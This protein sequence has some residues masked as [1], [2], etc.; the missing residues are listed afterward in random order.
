MENS[1]QDQQAGTSAEEILE[2]SKYA[3]GLF[4]IGT[5]EDLVLQRLI[6]RGLDRD[7]AQQILALR[8]QK[9]N[10]AQ[11]QASNAQTDKTG[12]IIIAVVLAIGIFILRFM[13]LRR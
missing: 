13:L 4:S 5:S 11:T 7:R 9:A 12:R 1:A 8:K 3:E 10:Q 6:D 2:Y